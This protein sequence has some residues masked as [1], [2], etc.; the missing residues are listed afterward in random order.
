MKRLWIVLAAVMLA[1]C[2]A[3]AA[4]APNWQPIG[5][6]TMPGDPN[7]AYQWIA[8]PSCAYSTGKCT[9]ITVVARIDCPT[10]VYAEVNEIDASGTVIGYSNDTLSALTA[11]QRGKL[12]FDTFDESVMKSQITK[13]SCF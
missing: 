4:P 7:L 6:T 12:E 10:T 3:A 9:A 13:A 11:G 5:F 2:S 1:G 8:A